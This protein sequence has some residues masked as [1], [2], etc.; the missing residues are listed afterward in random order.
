MGVGVVLDEEWREVPI[1]LTISTRVG[2]GA[3]RRTSSSS[4]WSAN[5]TDKRRNQRKH[6]VLKPCEFGA[7]HVHPTISSVRNHEESIAH[8]EADEFLQSNSQRCISSD[9][10][11]KDQPAVFL[12]HFEKPTVS[13]PSS[14]VTCKTRI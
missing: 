8:A 10:D 5:S 1:R 12:M 13:S 6:L 2:H 11:A 3:G 7:P 9:E 14:S 4:N